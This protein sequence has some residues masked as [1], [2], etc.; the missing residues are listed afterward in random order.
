[1]VADGLE[2]G[3]SEV[4]STLE[5]ELA[6]NDL[7]VAAG[8]VRKGTVAGQHWRWSGM[9]DGKE[10]VAHETIWRIHPDVAPDWADGN[11]WLR[12]KGNPNVNFEIERDFGF[13]DNGGIATAM[14]MVNAIPYVMD[15]EPGIKT[16]LDLPRILYRGG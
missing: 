3:V 11:N 10:V 4:V 15:A 2:L 6:E 1:M 12:F 9:A 16:L 13:M 8:T 7:E 14:H 5:T